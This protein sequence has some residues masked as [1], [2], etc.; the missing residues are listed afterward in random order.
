M[1]AVWNMQECT[2]MAW[3]STNDSF[4]QAIPAYAGEN[5]TSQ[6][7]LAKVGPGPWDGVS[8]GNFSLLEGLPRPAVDV[9]VKDGTTSYY[10]VFS[11][12]S[13]NLD[14]NMDGAKNATFYAVVYDDLDDG[15]SVLNRVLVDDDLNMTEEWWS[16]SNTDSSIAYKKDFYGN[17]GESISEKTGSLSNSIWSGNIRFGDQRNGSWEQQP[18]WRIEKYN[19]SDMLLLKDEWQING[20][21]NI[22]ILARAYSFDQSPIE[23]AN[24]SIQ[25]IRGNIPGMGFWKLNESNY[26]VLNIMNVTNQDGYAIL[27]IV[28][29][30]TW[31][32][33]YMVDVQTAS[34]SN[35]ETTNMWFRVV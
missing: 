10:G 32:G 9:R 20:T 14:L 26:G 27:R 15:Q 5:F 31:L 25:S 28:P 33:E 11:E 2:K 24:I 13:L 3:F 22:T 1:C 30:G 29:V 34:G 19:G 23:G 16:S 18:E 6:L 7:Y 12:S 35:T 4:S 8:I 21:R 17:E